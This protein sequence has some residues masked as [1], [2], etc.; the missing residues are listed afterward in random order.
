[1]GEE[2]S[3]GRERAGRRCLKGFGRRRVRV[4]VGEQLCRSAD[5]AMLVFPD[6]IVVG[7]TSNGIRT[8]LAGTNA[9]QSSRWREGTKRRRFRRIPRF[10]TLG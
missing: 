8:L 2:A 9:M 10:S 6:R 4:H 3:C 7:S 1:M 5:V